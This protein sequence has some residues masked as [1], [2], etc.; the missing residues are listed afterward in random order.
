MTSPPRLSHRPT[1]SI[2]IV[3]A[4]ACY[5]TANATE[6]MQR[7][8]PGFDHVGVAA[9]PRAPGQDAPYAYE[10]SRPQSVSGGKAT[11]A[12][13]LEMRKSD[14]ARRMFWIMLSMR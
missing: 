12:K 2:C 14:L 8:T 9:M 1:M 13:H 7:H 11:A 3:L 6:P 5:G 10:S 4:L